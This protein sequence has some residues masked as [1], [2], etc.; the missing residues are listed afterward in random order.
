[1]PA[2]DRLRDLKIELPEVA[3][4][5]G[6][7]APAVIAGEFLLVSGQI[8]VEAGVLRHL[9]KVGADISIEDAREAARIATV[10]AL[11]AARSAAG[12]LDRVDRVARLT[13]YVASASGFVEQ[14]QVANAA[15][16]LL[17]DVFGPECGIGARSA[18]GVAE[19]PAGACVEV[20]LTLR[21][22]D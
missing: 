16:E 4:P 8:P 21:L 5:A 6:L 18:I 20:E 9:G 11:A 14:P 10:N 3:P 7:Y 2:E 1:M 15:S 12:S 17:R 22:L 13:V 19:L